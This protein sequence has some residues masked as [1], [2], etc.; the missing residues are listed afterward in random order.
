MARL[1]RHGFPWFRDRIYAQSKGRLALDYIGGPEAIKGSAEQFDAVRTGIIDLNFNYC[2]SH[3]ALVPEY[4][5]MELWKPKLEG[6]T[7]DQMQFLN[8]AY[9]GVGVRW[10]GQI[11]YYGPWYIFMKEEVSTADDLKGMR[12]AASG[13]LHPFVVEGIGATPI[14]VESEEFF[15]AVQG[16]VVDGVTLQVEEW[17]TGFPEIIKQVILPAYKSMSNTSLFINLET[18]N[19]LPADLQQL[20]TDV[21]VSIYTDGILR[22]WGAANIDLQAWYDGGVE[23]VQLFKGADADSYTS[24]YADQI[25]KN[26]EEKVSPEAYKRIIELGKQ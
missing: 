19:S 16:G 15:T 26:T 2:S 23:P 25:L 8:E 7:Q 17:K 9:E 20:I 13:A 3:E 14:K 21:M 6:P 22:D 11:K 24:I 12:I 18:W 4:H 5:L 10:L 1:E